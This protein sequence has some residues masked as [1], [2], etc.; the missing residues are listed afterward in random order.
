MGGVNVTGLLVAGGLLIAGGLLAAPAASAE[1]LRFKARLSAP[2]EGSRGARRA[3]GVAEL[4]LDTDMRV[5]S[6]RITYTGL[7]GPVTGAHFQTPTE[8]NRPLAMPDELAPPYASPMAASALVDNI[9][10]G[11]LRAGLWSLVL[12]TARHPGGEITGGIE[13]A[14]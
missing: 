12:A 4:I 6:W 5:L 13:R 11:D 1:V 10:I 8:P 9:Q 3:S 14:P 7:T 2:V